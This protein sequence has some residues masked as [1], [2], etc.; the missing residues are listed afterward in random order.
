VLPADQRVDSGQ[1]AKAARKA[2]RKLFRQLAPPADRTHKAV[3][4]KE[5][6]AGAIPASPGKNGQEKARKKKEKAGKSSKPT[7]K[8]KSPSWLVS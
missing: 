5:S 8:V 6:A 3:P 4:A 2:A 7:A 1:A